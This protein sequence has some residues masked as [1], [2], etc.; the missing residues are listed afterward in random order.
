M[1]SRSPLSPTGSP[2]RRLL[3]GAAAAL[4]IRTA[5]P[6]PTLPALPA[7]GAADADVELTAQ[8]RQLHDDHVERA[9]AAVA[10]GR[11]DLL[12]ELSDS[13]VEQ[14]MALM[15]GAGTPP[16]RTAHPLAA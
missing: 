16:V 10:E 4:G 9:N 1:T 7:P 12:Q 6:A 3:A 11:E 13:Y 5:A 8:L 14:A 2:V 15:T